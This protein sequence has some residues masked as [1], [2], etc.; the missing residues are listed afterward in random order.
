MPDRVK[1][2]FVIFNIQALWRLALSVKVPGCKNYKWQLNPVGHGMLYSCTH[3]CYCC[4]VCHHLW[5]LDRSMSSLSLVNMPYLFTW[6]CW[7]L[8]VPVGNVA[9]GLYVSQSWA[10]VTRLA[11]FSPPTALPGTSTCPTMM[12]ASEVTTAVIISSVTMWYMLVNVTRIL[13]SI[14][15]HV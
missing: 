12:P 11:G 3:C 6:I 2:S 8:C 4:E 5:Q 10:A 7:R 14:F 15:C 1:P 13:V 9:I